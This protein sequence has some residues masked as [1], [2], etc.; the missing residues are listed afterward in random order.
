MKT[1]QLELS[2]KIYDRVINFLELLPEKECHI[3]ENQAT[4]QQTLREALNI[5]V[6]SNA[7][8]DIKE[9]AVWQSEIR[10]DRPLPGREE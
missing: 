6:R 5:A 9:P 2:D 10:K 1:I 7:F 3:F 8:A 4:Q